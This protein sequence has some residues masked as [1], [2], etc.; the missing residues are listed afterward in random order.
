MSPGFQIDS[1][2]VI[3]EQAGFH[4]YDNN[5]W[6][7]YSFD[8]VQVTAIGLGFMQAGCCTHIKLIEFQVRGSSTQGNV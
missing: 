5:G 4:E 1:D 8:S 3:R 2:G 7:C 6:I